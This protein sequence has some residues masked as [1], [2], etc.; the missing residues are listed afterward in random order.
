M[1]HVISQSRMGPWVIHFY[2]SALN[3]LLKLPVYLWGA[4]GQDWVRSLQVFLP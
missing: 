2:P 3:L 4:Q 1:L